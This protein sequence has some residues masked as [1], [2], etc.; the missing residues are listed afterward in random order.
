M[1]AWSEPGRKR[2]LAAES[3]HSAT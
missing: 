1:A 2:P 3:L